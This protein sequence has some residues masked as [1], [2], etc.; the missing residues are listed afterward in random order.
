MAR[1]EIRLCGAFDLR[2]DG[3][4]WPDLVARCVAPLAYILVH[5]DESISRAGLATLM[6]PD[7]DEETA[8]GNLRRRLHEIRRALPP[9][10][11]EWLTTT[12][13]TVRWESHAGAVLDIAEFE[14]AVNEGRFLDAARAYRGDFLEGHFDDW[15]LAERERL[16]SRYINACFDGALAARRGRDFETALACVNRV[17]ETD[18]W[19]E[20]ALRLAM[21]LHREA[22]D[23]DAA[24]RAYATFA[25]RL[26][27]EMH[28]EPMPETRALQEAIV[29]GTRETPDT[30]APFVGRASELE[31][32]RAICSR[33]ARGNGTTMFLAGDAG[34]GKSRL[35]S[36]LAMTFAEQ[37]GRTLFGVTSDPEAAPY[38]PIV[39]ALGR[40]ATLVLESRI[41]VIWLATLAQLVPA[42]LAGRPDLPVPEP[43][44]AQRAQQRLMEA[45]ARIVEHLARTR[46]LLLVLEDVHWAQ[47]AT[48]EAIEG[49]GRRIGTLPV[50]I[51]LTYR[52]NEPAAE[53]YLHPMR[54]RLQSQRRAA[55][56]VL[57]ALA[58]SDVEEMVRTT[59]S[60]A[61]VPD[62]FAAQVFALSEGNPLFANQLLR[63]FTETG[64]LPDANVA[65]RGVAQTILARAE[66]LDEDSR[67][68]ADVAS[69]IG[70]SF[71]AGIARGTLGWEQGRFLDAIGQL[72]DRAIVRE[73]GAVPLAYEFAHALIGTA[74]YDVIPSNARTA[75]HRRI[76]EVMLE[77]GDADRSLLA[78]IA[79]HWK[80]G[81]RPALAVP[82][83]ERAAAA[84]LDGYA[85]DAAIGYAREGLALSAE[86]A[87]RFSLLS[88]LARA[89]DHHG[90][91]AAWK[92]DVD[93]MSHI[94]VGLGDEERFAALT[95]QERYYAQTADRGAQRRTI[96]SMLELATGGAATARRSIALCALGSLEMV[97][98]RLNDAVTSLREAVELGG[99]E[100][101]CA[102]AGDR[103]A[104]V[105]ARVGSDDEVRREIETL[106]GEL[107]LGATLSRRRRYL[108]AIMS[109]ALAHEDP[110]MALEC[111]TGMLA[112][113]REIG[114]LETEVRGHVL[115]AFSAQHRRDVP[116]VRDHYGAA[117]TICERIGFLQGL[118]TSLQ[119]LG[120]AE[121]LFGRT[122][123]AIALYERALAI[124]EQMGS[125]MIV[126]FAL[127]NLADASTESGDPAA[128]LA[129]ANRA[130]ERAVPTG[131]LRLVAAATMAVGAATFATGDR[132]RGLGLM[133]E[134]VQQR[135]D[136]AAEYSLADDL[137]TYTHALFDAGRPEQAQATAAEIRAFFDT[138]LERV[139]QPT[140]LCWT[141]ARAARAAGDDTA[142]RAYADR[143]RA[144]LEAD[145]ALIG[146]PEIVASTRAMPFNQALLEWVS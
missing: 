145:L 50:F 78:A 142:A 43:L 66:S 71:P 134:A 127:L 32:L 83:Y 123:A 113:A 109:Y 30:Q 81:A 101:A 36:E 112:L 53:R 99:D 70:R 42:L 146:D 64:A 47:A 125:Q 48:L 61:D 140:R 72:L 111:G 58:L 19:R 12:P 130:L 18:E 59:P 7:D 33:A 124:A 120:A 86:P 45:I 82:A 21:A 90:D 85:R 122:S 57:R 8:R 128:G 11:L 92:R 15:V 98:G 51:V 1:F 62:G 88:L 24:L 108:T 95:A 91:L 84:A 68:L 60:I 100:Y 131:E 105:L 14:R 22:G 26:H 6:W 114:D 16:R 40:S 37:G 75:C 110:V 28:V 5:R 129:F 9:S 115:L 25:S 138:S 97:L 31:T 119:N 96:E 103:L 63:I 2:F 17:L 34:I 44:D 35:V 139:K 76:A 49:L 77:Q 116:G 27:A 143:G 87:R 144:L 13:T 104:Q 80:L 10:E 3:A 126:G 46:P 117:I 52:P 73:T 102:I 41:D 94:A 121:A 79:R 23:R 56:M 67:A 55:P 136:L 133:S 54:R 137:C 106:R 69:A 135:R 20:D 118:A 39:D 74:I 4:S 29:E 132:E 93:E 38:E 141:L 65:A 89:Q 107:A